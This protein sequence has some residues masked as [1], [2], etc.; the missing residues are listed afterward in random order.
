MTDEDKM[1]RHYEV[2]RDMIGWVIE[3]LT[4]EGIECERTEGND[5]NGDILIVNEK[6]LP[7]VKEIIRKIKNKYT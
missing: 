5:K 3:Q 1:I 2:H 4:K 7:R 6:D